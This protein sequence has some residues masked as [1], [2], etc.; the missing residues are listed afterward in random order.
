MPSATRVGVAVAV[1]SFVLSIGAAA[2]PLLAQDHDGHDHAE[3]TPS[4]EHAAPK[5]RIVPDDLTPAEAQAVELYRRAL[6]TVV[7]ILTKR[8]RVTSSGTATARSLGSGVLVSPR[9]HVLTAAHVVD[10]ADKI[11]VKT[12]DGKLRHGR[13]IQLTVS[14]EKRRG[15]LLE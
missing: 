12:H 7:T 10:G 2:T 9:R 11:M 1:I 8:R 3:R 4:P 6:P 15:S 5:Q 13:E 14:I